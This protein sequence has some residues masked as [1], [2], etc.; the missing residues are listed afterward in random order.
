MAPAKGGPELAHADQRLKK[1]DSAA[2]C[3]LKG[4]G[5]GVAVVSR[6]HSHG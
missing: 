3:F 2:T 4:D 6:T 5:N 1:A